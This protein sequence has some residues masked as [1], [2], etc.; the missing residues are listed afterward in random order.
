MALEIHFCSLVIR[1]SA[2]DTRYPG[3]W[4]A[5]LNTYRAETFTYDSELAKFEAMAPSFDEIIEGLERNGIL[6]HETDRP[7]DAAVDPL[8]EVPWLEFGFFDIVAEIKAGDVDE[9]TGLAY[10]RSETR[11][12]RAAACR[13][14]GGTDDALVG[15]LYT[16][17]QLAPGAKWTPWREA[18]SSDDVETR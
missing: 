3:G 2:I 17:W 5:F 18:E 9:N 14:A 15:R 11:R 12:D 13:L 16:P 4:T 8:G 1:R 10:E 7:G 6:L